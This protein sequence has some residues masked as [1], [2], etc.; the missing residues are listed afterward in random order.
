LC[1]VIKVAYV[2]N[3]MINNLAAANPFQLNQFLLWTIIG[4][5][6]KRYH[7]W[8]IVGNILPP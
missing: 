7:C 8:I 4:L 2:V 3:E 5:P 1:F 6:H